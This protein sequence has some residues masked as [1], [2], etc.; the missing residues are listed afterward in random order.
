LRRELNTARGLAVGERKKRW[1]PWDLNRLAAD[2]AADVLGAR[3][4][5]PRLMPKLPQPR[6]RPHPRPR[7][8]D[9]TD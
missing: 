3:K 7:P 5:M 1:R 4:A 6:R 8:A 9:E 2:I